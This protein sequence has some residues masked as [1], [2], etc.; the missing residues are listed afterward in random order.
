MRPMYKELLPAIGVVPKL[1]LAFRHAPMKYMG[2][3]LPQGL[4]EQTIAKLNHLIQHGLIDSS[5]ISRSVTARPFHFNG[6]TMNTS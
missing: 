2:L 5:L 1:P 3:G 4:V 6:L